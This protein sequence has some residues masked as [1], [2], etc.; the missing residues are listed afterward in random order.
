LRREVADLMRHF[1][2]E[3]EGIVQSRKTALPQMLAAHRRVWAEHVGMDRFIPR[4][5]HPSTR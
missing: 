2:P 5:R 4:T 1:I 3:Y